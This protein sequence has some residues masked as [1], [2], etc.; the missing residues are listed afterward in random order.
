MK[1]LMLSIAL[2]SVAAVSAYLPQDEAK[3]SQ[4]NGQEAHHVEQ[5]K[6][7]Q[8][9]AGRHREAIARLAAEHDVLEKDTR[10]ELP[11]PEVQKMKELKD[12]LRACEA[13]RDRLQQAL[14]KIRTEIKVEEAKADIREKDAQ[15]TVAATA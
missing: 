3:I 11:E 4:L 12:K 13:E 6:G 2:L 5:V 1:K 8:K 7:K 14:P 9:E 15:G 10:K